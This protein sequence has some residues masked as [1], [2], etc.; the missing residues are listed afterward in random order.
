[1]KPLHLTIGITLDA[2][3]VAAVLQFVRQAVEPKSED[4]TSESSLICAR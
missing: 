1:M 4:R 2:E 3:S